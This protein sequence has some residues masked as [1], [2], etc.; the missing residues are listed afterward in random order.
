MELN[1]DFDTRVVVHSDQIAW[2]PS[3]MPRV[4]RRMLDRIGAEVARATSIVRYAPNSNFSRHTHTGGE[5]FIVLDGVFQDEHGDYPA[6]TYVR[7]PP[8][9]AHTP[10]SDKGCTI[11]VKLWQFDMDDRTQF[12][13][14]MAA[15]L[16]ASSQGVSTATLHHDAFETV[17]FTR[18]D[19]GAC[20]ENTQAGGIEILVVAGSVTEHAEVLGKGAWLRLPAGTALDIMA[21]AEGADVWIKT[22]HLIHAKPPSATA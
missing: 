4:D 21:G 19:A 1:A 7:N 9:T 8:T 12:R 5:E 20:Y 15:E 16:G 10:G 22:G 17:T 13:K 14:D 18:L 6:G 11:F 3:P 2:T